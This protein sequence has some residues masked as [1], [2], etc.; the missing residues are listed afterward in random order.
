MSLCSRETLTNPKKSLV[1]NRLT[2]FD[3]QLHD[4]PELQ[5]KLSAGQL[6]GQPKLSA[7]HMVCRTVLCMTHGNIEM[8]L[9]VMGEGGRSANRAS[10]LLC[11]PHQSDHRIGVSH[12]LCSNMDSRG[13]NRGRP[14]EDVF[15]PSSK[16]S[17]GAAKSSEIRAV[18]SSACPFTLAEIGAACAS[19]KLT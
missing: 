9:S 2:P 4:L 7:N 18:E 17:S 5:P 10:S 12:L 8:L 1:R 16:S 14:G 15:K 11:A 13:A 3:L 19:C 6:R